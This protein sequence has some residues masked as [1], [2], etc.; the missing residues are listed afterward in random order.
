MRDDAPMRKWR[1][2]FTSRRSPDIADLT[3][4]WRFSR[5]KLASSLADRV[6]GQPRIVRIGSL[7]TGKATL[8]RKEVMPLNEV[9]GGVAVQLE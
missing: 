9:C 5:P 2:R 7:Q 8:L 4:V 3:A 1:K 6:L